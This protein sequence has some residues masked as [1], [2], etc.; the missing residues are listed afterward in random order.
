MKKQMSI[1]AVV[2]HYKMIILIIHFTWVGK[3]KNHLLVYSRWDQI[4]KS[5]S[6]TNAVQRGLY[7]HLINPTALFVSL[8]VFHYL[9]VF[10]INS[11][12]SLV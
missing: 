12:A 5:P 1:C 8:N 10:Y 9:S 6:M 7:S 4:L 11:L 2:I 3:G